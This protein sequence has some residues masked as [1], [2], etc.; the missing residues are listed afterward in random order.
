MFSDQDPAPYEIE[1]TPNTE[2]HYY[3]RPRTVSELTIEDL[4]R[5][6]LNEMV[7]IPSLDAKVVILLDSLGIKAAIV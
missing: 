5:P 2:H 4:G 3:T 7:L 6:S 1:V